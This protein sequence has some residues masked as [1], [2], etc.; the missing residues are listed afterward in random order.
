LAK[1]IDKREAILEAMLDLVVERG[2]HNSPMSLLARKSGASPGVIYHYFESKDALI[3]ALY[4]HVASI[5]R[6][7]FFDGYSKKM[8]PREALL[9][10]WM[11]AYRFYRAHRKE[12]RFLDQY[13]N[14][15]YC[16]SRD[17]DEQDDEDPTIARIQKLS[18]PSKKGGVMKDLPP[19][20]IHSLTLGLA[21]NLAKAKKEFPKGTL[22][23]IADTVWAA[24]ADE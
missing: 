18:R 16:S 9:L 4:Q 8:S 17:L 3:H 6:N 13:L 7:V 14:S 1:K 11:N 2:F 21:A 23:E 10:V 12:T 19:E 5:K 24:I 20:A 15:P 22:R